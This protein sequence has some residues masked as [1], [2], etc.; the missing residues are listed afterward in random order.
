M[1]YIQKNINLKMVKFYGERIVEIL[2][3]SN[4][5]YYPSLKV[6]AERLRDSEEKNFKG[7]WLYFS[8][9]FDREYDRICK[10]INMPLRT[11][12]YRIN[13]KHYENQKHFLHIYMFS[14]KEAVIDTISLVFSIVMLILLLRY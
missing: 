12:V 4:M 2:D 1:I 10:I 13:R 9:R 5:Y 8:G 11:R 3:E 7:L 14:G 6:Y